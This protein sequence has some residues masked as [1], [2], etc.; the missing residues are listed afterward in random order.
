MVEK[1]SVI[2]IL[3]L[4]S[5]FIFA[6]ESFAQKRV[7]L[8]IGNS[9]YQERSLRNPT[10]D[11]RDIS[12]VLR[13]LGFEVDLKLDASQE[14]MEDA[15][16]RFG[17]ELQG[18]TVGLF[19]YSGHGVQYEGSNYLIPIG[20]MSRV[21][22]PEHLRY[23]TVDA[24]Y[25]LGVMKQAGNGLNIV[26]LDA[27]RNNPFKSFS[28]SMSR[29]LKRISGAEGTIIAYSTSPGKVALDGNRRNSPY[30]EQLI[31]LMQKP[32]LPVEIMFK[33]VR[34]RVKAETDGK[35]SPWYEASIEG[36]FYFLEQFDTQQKKQGIALEEEEV[37]VSKRVNNVHFS[38]RE[39][40]FIYR[41]PYVN[42]RNRPASTVS[43]VTSIPCGAVVEVL[44]YAPGLSDEQSKWYH[45]QTKEGK[46]GWTYA[47]EHDSWLQSSPPKQY[48]T[49]QAKED[50][51]YFIAQC[52]YV[53][54]RELPTAESSILLHLPCG[55]VVN[56]IEY[57]PSF[58]DPQYTWYHIRS[59]TGEEDGWVYGGE[60]NSWLQPLSRIQEFQKS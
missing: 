26:V 8:V 57:S 51:L 36:D 30:T 49:S 35:Q 45:I 27:C 3:L 6:T 12:K 37:I 17:K 56:I 1:N 48:K 7:A 13:S 20:A 50:E 39:R 19:Y 10:N 47:G 28:R 2:K 21:S 14:D 15:V 23:K 22:A 43:I 46:E 34:K 32:N 40:Q 54:L 29:G 44:G 4:L 55:I 41:C 5:C 25:V 11:A 52:P 38:E 60:E 9:H 24:G 16:Q 53:N 58:K 31:K 59:Q 18:N 33:Q 42:V